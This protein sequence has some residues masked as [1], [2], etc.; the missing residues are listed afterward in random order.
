[1]KDKIAPQEPM[2]VIPIGM[3]CRK[4]NGMTHEFWVDRAN[5]ALKRMKEH[6]SRDADNE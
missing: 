3:D 6:L 1:M 2:V 5:C 4:T